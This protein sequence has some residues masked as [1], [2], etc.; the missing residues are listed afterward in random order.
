MPIDWQQYQLQFRQHAS[1]RGLS[2]YDIDRALAYASALVKSGVPII[3]SETH[4]AQ[5]WG[6]LEQPLNW[7][8]Q[9]RRH[10]LYRR[11]S[12][13]KRSG[14]RR[15]IS[16]PVQS[17]RQIQQWILLNVLNSM[18]AHPCAFGFVRGRSIR[19]NA[20][21]HVG[22]RH[23][24]SLDIFEFFSSIQPF[25]VMRV[26]RSVGY[27]SSVA[28]LLVDATTVD[29]CL[30][31]GAPTS[32]A[33]SNLVMLEVDRALSE[34]ARVSRLRYSRYA[35]DLTFSGTIRVDGVIRYVREQ[36][37]TVGLRLNESKTRLMSRH[38]RQEV[39]GIVVN[40]RMQ[41]S[42]QKR[43]QLRQVTHFVSKFGLESHLEKR[44]TLF[45]KT[46]LHLL[47]AAQF[48][49]FVNPH[50]RDAAE[51]RR[52]FLPMVKSKRTE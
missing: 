20:A 49:A 38:E 43:R 5:L 21:I 27:S 34:Y 36:L 6:F 52:V 46:A 19:D 1:E 40:D 8:L 11:F 17:L 23:V 22:Q 48:V 26:F 15:L 16:S 50:D 44:P 39:T 3:Y 28:Q 9:K 41:V 32:P 10:K 33:L 35:D 2:E 29:R 7:V 24:L 14:G 47:G 45:Q 12:I 42:R 25:Y 30:P 4:L 37:R 18:P 51:A 31:Q 13:L